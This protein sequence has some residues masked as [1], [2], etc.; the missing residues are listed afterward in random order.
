VRKKLRRR[1]IMYRVKGI[2]DLVV[3]LMKR[4]QTNLKVCLVVVVVV[5]V[6]LAM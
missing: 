6:M 4:H 5:V 3:R 1:F 2:L